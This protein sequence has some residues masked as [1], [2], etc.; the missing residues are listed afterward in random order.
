MHRVFSLYPKLQLF[1]IAIF[2]TL[3]QF[4]C[5]GYTIQYAKENA[6]PFSGIDEAVF[7]L[8]N[9]SCLLVNLP[10]AMES[11]VKAV[12]VPSLHYCSERMDQTFV[13]M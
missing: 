4:N 3:T 2:V 10:W 6:S 7:K 13:L 1:I 12:A 5:G 9:L 8:P 11:L